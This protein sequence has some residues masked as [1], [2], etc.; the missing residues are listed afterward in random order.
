MFFYDE[1][2]HNRHTSANEIDGPPRIQSRSSSN[3]IELEEEKQ[4]VHSTN[5]S[6]VTDNSTVG[7]RRNLSDTTSKRGNAIT[8]STLGNP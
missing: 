8:L 4:P 5:Y 6:T 2:K 3:Y 7:R 1:P